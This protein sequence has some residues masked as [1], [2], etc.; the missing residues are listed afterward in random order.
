MGARG[1]SPVKSLRRCHGH[2]QSLKGRDERSL[3]PKSRVIVPQ[4]F[5]SLFEPHGGVLAPHEDGCIALWTPSEYEE[6]SLRQSLR[7][8]EGA[9]AGHEARRWFS[10]CNDFS[11]DHQGRMILPANLREHAQIGTEVLFFGV[12]DRVE[13]WSKQVWEARERSFGSPES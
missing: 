12:F 8:K 4:R 2:L 5:R 10:M 7:F 3:D 1:A 9:T 11:L 13:L 6:E